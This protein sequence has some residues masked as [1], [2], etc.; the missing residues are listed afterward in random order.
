MHLRDYIEDNFGRECIIEP[1]KLIDEIINQQ[2][3]ELKV[4]E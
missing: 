4:I 3:E 2:S 1:L